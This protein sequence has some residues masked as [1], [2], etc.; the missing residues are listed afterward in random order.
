MIS[1]LTDYV[2][3]Y[4]LPRNQIHGL[5][6]IYENALKE[7]LGKPTHLAKDHRKSKNTYFYR[8]EETWVDNLNNFSLVYKF[9]CISDLIRF[10][11]KEVEKIMIR[12][13]HKYDFYIARCVGTHDREDCNNMDA[14]NND[15]KKCL[16]PFNGIQ[17]EETYDRR[18]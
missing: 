1:D 5:V 17:Y 7:S 11:V 4:G 6:A 14:K 15:L 18:P 9:C 3:S 13:V 2:C 12:S 10:M 16:L 8:Y